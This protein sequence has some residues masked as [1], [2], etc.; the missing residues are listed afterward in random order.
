MHKFDQKNIMQMVLIGDVCY[1]N[2]L[3]HFERPFDDDSD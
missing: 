2:S 3:F 1:N